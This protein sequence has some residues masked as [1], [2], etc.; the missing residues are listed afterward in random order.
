MQ[1]DSRSRHRQTPPALSLGSRDLQTASQQM[2]VQP[3]GTE[4]SLDDVVSSNCLKPLFAGRQPPPIGGGRMRLPNAWIQRPQ[5]RGG[6]V[7]GGRPGTLLAEVGTLNLAEA[8][9]PG[10]AKGLPA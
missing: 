10:L 8:W 2:A 6:L 1:T 3:G 4:A 9:H 5:I 7:H